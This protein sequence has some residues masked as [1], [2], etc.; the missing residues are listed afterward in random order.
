[1]LAHTIQQHGLDGALRRITVFDRLSR[2][3]ESGPSRQL[4]TDSGKYGL[5]SGGYQAEYLKLTEDGAKA[6]NPQ[7][8][9]QQRKR[10]QFE[11]AVKRIE[12]F[13]ML[14]ERLKDKRV[15]AL[16]VM[17]DQL[18]AIP[19]ADREQC[20]RVFMENA[21]Y[22]ELIRDEAG[23]DRII[24]LDQAL[25]QLPAAPPPHER[26]SQPV[27]STK[28]GEGATSPAPAEP[29]LHIDV[30]IHID[31]AASAEQIDQLFASMARHLYGRER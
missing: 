1:V 9:A 16:D 15:P 12:P 29:T 4:V 31:S 19:E 28:Q 30:N 6:V 20:C 13:N 27:K 24:G 8:D 14:Y 23:G 21:R 25:E 5:T 7:T 17:K 26:A 11:L 2:S 18:D 22:L 10:V 3:A